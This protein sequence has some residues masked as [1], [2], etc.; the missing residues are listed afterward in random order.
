MLAHDVDDET[1]RNYWITVTT[2]CLQHQP[3][4]C[5]MWEVGKCIWQLIQFQ[6]QSFII[7]KPTISSNGWKLNQW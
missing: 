1:E 4:Y 7:L 2:Y 3:N 6:N 5:I